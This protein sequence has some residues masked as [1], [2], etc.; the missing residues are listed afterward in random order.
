MVTSFVEEVEL[1]IFYPMI[2]FTIYIESHEK[3]LLVTSWT[4][5]ITS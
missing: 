1:P 2:A 3:M 5:V 4:E